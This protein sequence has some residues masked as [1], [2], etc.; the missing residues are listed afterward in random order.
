MLVN[1]CATFEEV[2]DLVKS[3]KTAN[4]L[5]LETINLS[6]S[7]SQSMSMSNHPED[8]TSDSDITE[9]APMQP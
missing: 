9:K 5:E 2:K 4:E 1:T 3:C 8:G 7:F 6:Q